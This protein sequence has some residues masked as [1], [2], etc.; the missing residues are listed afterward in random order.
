MRP[1]FSSTKQAA[2]FALLLLVLL[3]LPAVFKKN[4]LPPREQIYSSTACVAGPYHNL[5][6]QIFQDQGDIDIAFVGSSSLLHAIDT[7]YVQQQL[8]EKLGRKASVV[9]VCWFWSGFDAF[10]FIAQDL[11][12]HRKVHMI[13]FTDEGQVGDSP[14]CMAYHWFRFGDNAGDLNGI[15]P[16]FQA[17]YYFAA[18]IGMPRNLLSLIRP[19]FPD[20]SPAGAASWETLWR[21]PDPATTLGA[22]FAKLGYNCPSPAHPDFVEYSPASQVSPA[23]VCIF[24]PATKTQFQF[25]KSV[26]SP[27]QLQFARKFAALA[28]EHQCKLVC[29]SAPQPMPM[30]MRAPVIKEREFWPDAMQAEVSMVGIPPAKLFAGLKDEDVL[31]LFFNPWHFNKN[32]QEFFTALVTPSLLHLYDA[33]AKH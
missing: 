1:A 25:S 20:L 13:V 14:Q 15:A 3:L 17:A 6:Q 29:L 4:W 31:K 19:N 27:M 24:S 5:L 23:D 12:Q 7:Q 28:K 21:A 18:I 30:E 26:A 33:E 2:A 8:S 22:V 16:R 32:G 9:T 11:L 10:Y